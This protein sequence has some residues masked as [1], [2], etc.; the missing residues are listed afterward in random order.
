MS[1]KNR[2]LLSSAGMV[3]FSLIVMMLVGGNVI[4]LFSRGERVDV[5]MANEDFSEA[6][7]LLAGYDGTASTF[8][9]L[10]GKLEG[11]GYC[12][13]VLCDGQMLYT[14]FGSDNEHLFSQAAELPWGD[15][16]G[17]VSVW[18]ENIIGRRLGDKILIARQIGREPPQFDGVPPILL[19]FLVSGLA[20][21][22]PILLC[23]QIFTNRVF[24][25]I[26]RPLAELSDAAR[27]VEQG[28][29]TQPVLIRGQNEFAEVCETFNNMQQ[30]LLAEREKNAAYEKVRTD[31]VSGIS[32]DLRT[33]LTSVKGYIKGLQDGIASTPE[34]QKQYLA[35]AYER[36][37]DMEKLI[38]GLLDFS[39]LESGR[40]P[41]KFVYADLG[42]FALNYAEMLQTEYRPED[43]CIETQVAPG[44]HPVYM[45]EG[46]MRRV[47]SNLAD[48]AVKYA[49]RLPLKLKLQVFDQGDQV[50][51]SFSD[52]G[53]GVKEDQL[54]QIFDE[55][56]RG[57]DSRSSQGVG[58]SGL[59]LYIVK[60]IIEAHGGS[61]RA[62]NCGGLK[63]ALSL[64]RREESYENTDR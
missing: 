13:A 20:A 32:H 29:L 51:L 55:F 27:R 62:E 35:V 57:D 44:R 37:C 56:W 50:C 52:N 10:A 64:P 22:I 42:D 45:D 43:V 16:P 60:Y 63:I 1:L 58:G 15:I 9:D 28:D 53:N 31:L 26:T 39:R 19:S 24:K 54:S 49:G 2:I 5:V 47:L 23:S 12:L 3:L 4:R 46:Q 34:K 14:N 30:H 25:R 18:G 33:P 11:T 48:N 21:V 17:A 59:G 61:V 36:A 8:A 6:A 41:M 40:I 7:A 38:A